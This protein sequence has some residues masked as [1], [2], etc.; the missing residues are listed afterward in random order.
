MQRIPKESLTTYAM[1][2]PGSGKT[3]DQLRRTSARSAFVVIS[4]DWLRRVY[5]REVWA[6]RVNTSVL[7]DK[8]AE[9]N[10]K[11]KPIMF[12]IEAS[13][14]Q[15]LFFDQLLEMMRTRRVFVPLTPIKQPTNVEKDFRIRAAI[16]PYLGMGRLFIPDT[17]D[18]FI[19]EFE[20]ELRGFP[21]A[22]TKD[23]V[24]ALASV[25][26]MI[27]QI[28]PQREVDDERNDRVEYLRSIGAP[29][30]YIEQVADG[31]V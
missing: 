4:V 14:Q 24:D 10:Q 31:L 22:R 29:P 15:S 12:G 2:D 20:T 19:I 7:G 27:P 5:V 26:T 16:Q 30:E 11:W 1:L 28:Q 21:V 13:A 3:K 23:I 25:L 6:G 9:L 8:I 18:P 17:G